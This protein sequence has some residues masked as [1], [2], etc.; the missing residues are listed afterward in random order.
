M[1]T[2][3]RHSTCDEGKDDAR[4]ATKKTG[5]ETVVHDYNSRQIVI[6]SAEFGTF[7]KPTHKA[8]LRIVDVNTGDIYSK[9]GGN[10]YTTGQN[11]F[12]ND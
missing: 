9:E 10:Y 3:C 6:Y 4:A 5:T 8:K 12:R 2:A 11:A 7:H 1:E